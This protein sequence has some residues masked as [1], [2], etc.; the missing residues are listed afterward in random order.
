M[1]KVSLT[2]IKNWFKTGL[3][4]TQAQFW[5]VFDSFRHKDDA[6]PAA[7]VSGL[8][9]LLVQKV[10]TSHLTDPNAHNIDNIPV[11]FTTTATDKDSLAVW[12]NAQ[13][14]PIEITANQIPE[15]ELIDGTR[16]R[17]ENKG[18]GIYGVGQTQVVAK[19][20]KL[21]LDGAKTLETITRP[22]IYPLW[23]VVLDNVQKI[24]N[25]EESGFVTNVNEELKVSSI[26]I[27]KKN[28]EIGYGFDLINSG[29]VV[30][31][32]AELNA[33]PHSDGTTVSVS[34]ASTTYLYASDTGQWI[35]IGIF[36]A[37]S[38]TFAE[39]VQEAEY[40]TVPKSTSPDY[41]LIAVTL[42]KIVTTTNGEL[43]DADNVQIDLIKSF[44]IFPTSVIAVKNRVIGNDDIV[45]SKKKLNDIYVKVI[46]N[47]VN[48]FDFNFDYRYFSFTGNTI[49]K[50]RRT[51]MLNEL[52]LLKA[53]ETGGLVLTAISGNLEGTI[54][55][56]TGE[57]DKFTEPLQTVFDNT[58]NEMMVVNAILQRDDITQVTITA[59]GNDATDRTSFATVTGKKVVISD[60]VAAHTDKLHQWFN[61]GHDFV[62]P[63]EDTFIDTVTDIGTELQGNNISSYVK[64]NGGHMSLS[65]IVGKEIQSTENIDADVIHVT[66]SGANSPIRIDWTS[67]D[68]AFRP[69]L[70]IVGAGLESD[71]DA[72]WQ[73]SF[74]FGM[75]FIEP[76]SVSTV[77]DIPLGDTEPDVHQQSPATAIVAG[78][79]RA[80]KESVPNA[81]WQ[82]VRLAARATATRANQW[83]MYRGFGVIDTAAAIVQLRLD[84]ERDSLVKANIY[85]R[86]NKIAKSI[87]FLKISEDAPVAKRHIASLGLVVADDMV[88]K[89]VAI[90]KDDGGFIDLKGDVAGFYK[91]KFLK[92]SI[93]RLHENEELAN[94]TAVFLPEAS[95]TG[96][97]LY[98]LL[99]AAIPT[100][101]F[102]TRNSVKYGHRESLKIVEFSANEPAIDYLNGFPEL[103]V[104][105]Q[106]TNLVLN[107]EPT[108]NE[109]AASAGVTYQSVANPFGFASFVKI[110]KTASS[111]FRYGATA[112]NDGWHKQ[113]FYFFVEGYNLQ[114]DQG[115]TTADKV[116]DL[117]TRG[118]TSS[119]KSAR[120]NAN[121]RINRN[122]VF[123]SVNAD[124]EGST[125]TG[126]NGLI[127]RN[128][129][130]NNDGVTYSGIMLEASTKT[131]FAGSYI[132]TTGATKTVNAD[133][134]T[135]SNLL[136]DGLISTTEGT[137]IERGSNQEVRTVWTGG[138]RLKF[139]DNALISTVAEVPND[140]PFTLDTSSYRLSEILISDKAIFP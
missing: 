29:N 4:P 135:I 90:M 73:T 87:D 106:R 23:N 133:V 118:N 110:P 117:V 65:A 33:F 43:S 96:G 104:E 2:T 48:H 24:I 120:L 103:I 92:Q 34:F 42:D 102:L 114:L 93:K 138:N 115:N 11:T 84:V 49:L 74:G 8:D 32:V 39:I 111:E 61:Y 35:L 37:I 6:V 131:S 89:A 122:F 64:R 45:F 54:E 113:Q 50:E 47:D 119:S 63:F 78:K 101:F 5:D 62:M 30:F 88:N 129:S 75:E 44:S 66:A 26:E 136:A 76:T 14:P 123:T 9:S 77:P 60:T 95:K 130:I 7:E 124:S 3:K 19:D 109:A 82:Q 46:A 28:R 94:L 25:G 40:A 36:T 139:I 107:S 99:N 56:V 83:D 1:A 55:G 51:L 70:V 100:H 59:V 22:G 12:L 71:L 134:F 97:K 18:K 116:Y 80:I 58:T 10:E 27:H 125:N 81:T 79:L 108:A 112:A 98:N 57:G 67:G 105:P 85:N 31:S 17:F 41:G 69:N 21:V 127:V 91:T 68:K 16:Y 15:W 137:I 53:N 38:N 126:N 20:F 13:T 121:N 52:D 72:N 132:R 86:N 140:N 128:T